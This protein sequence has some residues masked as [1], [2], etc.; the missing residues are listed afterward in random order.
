MM[1]L[2]KLLVPKLKIKNNYNL[3][4]QNHLQLNNLKLL[5]VSLLMLIQLINLLINFMNNLKL[6]LLII[7]FV[8]NKLKK[9]NQTIKFMY[10]IKNLK[11]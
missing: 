7:P 10:L 8:D 6:E 3:N 4:N 1:L 11:I 5:T 9:D 2:L